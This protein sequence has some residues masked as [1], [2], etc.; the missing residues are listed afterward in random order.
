MN[1]AAY[2]T[3]ARA[4]SEQSRDGRPG[5]VDA[6]LRRELS[7]RANR[8]KPAATVSPESA[9]AAVHLRKCF[10]QSELVKV[11]VNSDNRDEVEA[12][13][14]R[15]A[16]QVPCEVVQRIGFVLTLYRPLADRACAGEP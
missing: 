14:A 3:C 7:A 9:D 2:V 8:L 5:N 13:G 1:D 12:L 10:S 4:M 15:L 16:A 11:R 6:D